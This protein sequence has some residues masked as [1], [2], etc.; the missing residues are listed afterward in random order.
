MAVSLSALRAG[1][2]ALYPQEDSSEMEMF[3]DK[4]EFLYQIHN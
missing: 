1:L 4:S 2:A 3:S